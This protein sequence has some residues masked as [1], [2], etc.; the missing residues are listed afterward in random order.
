MNYV[1]LKKSY[2]SS[3]EIIEFTKRFL[4][5][6]AIEAIERHGE[7]PE[8]I[9]VKDFDEQG[10]L[11]MEQ[12]K[13]FQNETMRSCGIVC[14]TEEQ[15]AQLTCIVESLWSCKN[16]KFQNKGAIKEVILL[17]R[18]FCCFY[19]ILCLKRLNL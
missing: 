5:E 18:S 2:R 17:N 12:L 9:Q 3:Y 6:G 1:E 8:I 16:L 7:N 10:R 13:A 15:V 14:K 4:P 11:L 19:E